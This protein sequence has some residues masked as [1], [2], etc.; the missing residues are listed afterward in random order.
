[1]KARYFA[2]HRI[3]KLTIENEVD[4]LK[5]L[6]TGAFRNVVVSGRDAVEER[7]LSD[8]LREQLRDAE[9]AVHVRPLSEGGLN[10]LVDLIL[11]LDGQC[12]TRVGVSTL[13]RQFHEESKAERCADCGAAAFVRRHGVMLCSR[14][15]LERIY[16]RGPS[17]QEGEQEETP[18]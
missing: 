18:S 4:V 15:Y 14:C 12:A 2:E 9:F 13:A 11:C 5:L 17:E 8:R 16:D 6:R 7:R 10:V 1:M 3:K